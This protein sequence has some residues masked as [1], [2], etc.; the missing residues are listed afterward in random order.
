[1]K[2]AEEL[3]TLPSP[4]AIGNAVKKSRTKLGI[5]SQRTFA[6]VMGMGWS[7]ATVSNIERGSRGL[8][9]SELRR[10]L[11]LLQDERE[12][13]VDRASAWFWSVVEEEDQR[14][15]NQL[16]SAASGSAKGGLLEAA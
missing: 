12:W 11:H 9:A 8:Q 16:T 10:L 14:R 3:M 5:R 13:T 15:T 1:M 2:Q 7:Q 4:R 6:K